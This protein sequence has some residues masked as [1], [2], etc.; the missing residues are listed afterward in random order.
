[1]QTLRPEFRVDPLFREL[2]VR[3]QL[4]GATAVSARGRRRL[5]RARHYFQDVRTLDFLL[6]VL[7]RHSDEYDRLRCEV[8]LKYPAPYSAGDSVCTITTAATSG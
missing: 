5:R 3:D 1:M 8:W 4:D 2:F 7:S 6:D